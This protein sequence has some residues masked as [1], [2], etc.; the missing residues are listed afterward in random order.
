MF[1]KAKFAQIIKKIS[2]TYEN[3]RNFSQK[4]E[5]NR[6]S[7]SQYINMKLD[8]PPKPEMLEKLAN[9]SRG[10]TT[11][12][13]LMI[14]CGYIEYRENTENIQ[15]I[16][17]YKIGL[18]YSQLQ[19]TINKVLSLLLTNDELKKVLNAFCDCCDYI[20]EY[21]NKN[22]NAK[23][24]SDFTHNLVD[25][26]KKAFNYLYVSLLKRLHG[27]C[28]VP[29]KKDEIISL[30]KHL[31]LKEDKEDISLCLNIIIGMKDYYISSIKNYMINN[32][33]I[34]LY[35]CPVYGRISSGQ[36]NWA[37]ECIEGRL[38][39]DPGL[40]GIVNPEEHFFLRVNGES[41]NKV[42]RNDAFALIHKQD[43]VENGE[44]AVVLVNGDEA[45]IKR[46]NKQGDLIILEPMSDDPSFQVQ[47]YN[48]TTPIKILGKYVGKMEMNK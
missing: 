38:P 20:I 25:D 31:I 9:A 23:K 32:P 34:N 40:M 30:K 21:Y 5:I 6:T 4:A 3:Q 2:D 42:I 41:M 10:I 11:Y 29:R 36:P 33:V 1:D 45:T 24:I 37:E 17:S 27:Y 7:L 26:E 15:T 46:F 14:I 13:E 48:K 35:M 44:I 16:V 18:N 47:V 19:N 39:I 43:V 12:Q 8:K 28:N 22:L